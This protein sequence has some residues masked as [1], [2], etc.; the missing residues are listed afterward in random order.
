MRHLHFLTISLPLPLAKSWLIANNRQGFDLPFYDIFAP[1]KVLKI[2][3]DV[4][5]CSLWFGPPPTKNLGYTYGYNHR[6]AQV[7]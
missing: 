5:A 7:R 1:Q 4:N 2:F 3:D 6:W